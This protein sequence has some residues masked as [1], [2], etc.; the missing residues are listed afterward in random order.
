VND[1]KKCGL[2]PSLVRR[3]ADTPVRIPIRKARKLLE[4]G[5]DRLR[6]LPVNGVE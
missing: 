6:S 4:S 5:E 2:Y 1:L 3:W